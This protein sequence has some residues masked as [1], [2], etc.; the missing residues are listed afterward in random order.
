M[1]CEAE[2]CVNWTGQGCACEFLDLEP[3]TWCVTCQKSHPGGCPFAEDDEAPSDDDSDDD[4][5]GT[6]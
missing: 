4:G 5:D 3:Q 6:E 1:A 2:L